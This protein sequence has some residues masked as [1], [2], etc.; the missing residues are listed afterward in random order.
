MCVY[1]Y[2]CKCVCTS[3]RSHHSIFPLPSLSS[4]QLLRGVTISQGG[5]LPHIPEVLLFKK[6]QLRGLAKPHALPAKK[7][8][9]LPKKPELKVSAVSRVHVFHLGIRRWGQVSNRCTYIMFIAQRQTVLLM[10]HVLQNSH[11]PANCSLSNQA[12][13]AGLI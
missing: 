3:S 5:V 7:T 1:M 4:P 10:L 2:M 9:P 11:I 13:L 6:S 12:V 8:P